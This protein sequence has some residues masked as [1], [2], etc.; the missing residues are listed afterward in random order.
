MFLKRLS[1]KE[2]RKVLKKG[3][4]RVDGSFLPKRQGFHIKMGVKEQVWKKKERLGQ[5]T[6]FLGLLVLI[7]A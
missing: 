3:I 2:K 7:L 1:Y 4:Q 5:G 6:A